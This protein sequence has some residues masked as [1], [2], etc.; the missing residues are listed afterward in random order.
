[1]AEINCKACKHFQDH[2]VMGVCRRYPTFVNRHHTEIC[3]EFSALPV[4]L[5][6][7]VEVIA[8]PVMEMRD[9]PKKRGRPRMAK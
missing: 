8:L 7:P 2:G 1:M 9:E 6:K 5:K 3:G 4:E